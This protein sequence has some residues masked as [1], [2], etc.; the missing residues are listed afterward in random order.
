MVGPHH[1]GQRASQPLGGCANGFLSSHS[2][3]YGKRSK[4]A[5]PLTYLGVSHT[6]GGRPRL[7]PLAPF[8]LLHAAVSMGCNNGH[9]IA[10]WVVS[11]RQTKTPTWNLSEEEEEPPT[12]ALYSASSSIY[13]VPRYVRYGV[14]CTDRT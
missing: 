5:P 11:G 4:V 1:R 6:T 14:V 8:T 12:S 7:R 10:G 3:L 2:P 13:I 9:C